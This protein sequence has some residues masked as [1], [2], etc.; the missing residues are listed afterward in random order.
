MLFHASLLTW[1]N[2]GAK[3]HHISFARPWR[4]YQESELHSTFSNIDMPALPQHSTG[5]TSASFPRKL[6]QILNNSIICRQAVMVTRDILGQFWPTP[7]RNSSLWN[8]HTGASSRRRI[9]KS[10]T[11][12]STEHRSLCHPFAQV[13]QR[14]GVWSQPAARQRN[15]CP[16]TPA[17]QLLPSYDQRDI[18]FCQNNPCHA[19][20]HV[21]ARP[22]KV[23]VYE[24]L[25]KEN[26]TFYNHCRMLKEIKI[27]ATG[28]KTSQLHQPEE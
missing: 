10:H 21:T 26:W 5:C 25:A 1:K 4:K 14:W 8:G 7:K 13:P 22:A 12:T 15:I 2:T 16:P 9:C 19:V 24:R 11:P 27:V 3:W 6:S 18:W 23:C 28:M 20:C 17:L